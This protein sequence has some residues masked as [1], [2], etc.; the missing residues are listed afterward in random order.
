MSR[1]GVVVRGKFLAKLIANHGMA[2]SLYDLKVL[3]VGGIDK[4]KATFGNS[5]SVTPPQ[6]LTGQHGS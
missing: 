4:E 3:G 6:S 2:A 1:H 5:A